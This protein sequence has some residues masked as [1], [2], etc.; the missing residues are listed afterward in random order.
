MMQPY[1]PGGGKAI[2]ILDDDD[3]PIKTK[4]SGMKLP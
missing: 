4:K 3:E 2:L 1:Q